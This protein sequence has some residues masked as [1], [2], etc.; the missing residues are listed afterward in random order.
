MKKIKLVA[1]FLGLYSSS[2]S[3]QYDTKIVE[4]NSLYQVELTEISDAYSIKVVYSDLIK[5][6]AQFI[7]DSLDLIYNFKNNQL[8]EDLEMYN[9]EVEMLT[10]QLKEAKRA[11]RKIERK[12]KR[13]NE[14]K[15]NK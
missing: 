8:E 15:A 13:R 12:I 11:K 3:A 5:E 14:R 6:K 2:L 1:I 7:K 9:Q 4:K 10:M